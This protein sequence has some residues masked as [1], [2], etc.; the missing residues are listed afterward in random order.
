MDA[1]APRGLF[2]YFDAMEDPRRPNAR[3]LLSD[4][5]AMTIIATCCGAR[6]W[7]DVALCCQFK[8]KWLKTFLHLPHGIPSHDTFGRVF[9]MIDPEQL[10]QCFLAWTG[11]LAERSD[12]RL[13]AVDG[14][15]I[16]RSF[17]RADDKAA[18][19]MVSAWCDHNQMVLGQLATDAKS[20]E[21]TAVPKLLELLDL[22]GAIVTVDAMNCQKQTA[23][24][25]IAG[26]GDYV[27]QVKKNQG[28]LHE[29]LKLCLDEAIALNFHGV[30]HDYVEDVDAGHGRIETRRLWCTRDITWLPG[31]D[32]W[33]GL[34]SAAVVESK[35]EVDGEISIERR[36]FISSLPGDD[37]A[38]ILKLVRGHW[39]IENQLHWSLDVSFG[40]DA[41]RIRKDHAAENFSRIRRLVLNLLKRD[42]TLKVGLEAKMKGCSWNHDYLLK[43]LTPT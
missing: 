42:K 32:D 26:G 6:G 35:R 40:E 21:I 13:V 18:I 24:K 20:N 8:L 25:I 41:S 30:P 7:V 2:G 29:Q 11:A 1:D 27:M 15:T 23:S 17:D 34:V 36:Y 16:R 38:A 4:I 12:Q 10:E 33:D 19:Q 22:N 3:H 43:V 14:K 31:G 39:R 5:I 28:K 37:A 9:G